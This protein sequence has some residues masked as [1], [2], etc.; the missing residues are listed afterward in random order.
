[1]ACPT[2]LWHYTFIDAEATSPRPATCES[3]LSL[4]TVRYRYP[5]PL[6]TSSSSCK[7]PP[8]ITC[9]QHQDVAGII[10]LERIVHISVSKC[11]LRQVPA[12]TNP[13]GTSY[14]DLRP[15]HLSTAELQHASSKSSTTSMYFKSYVI[16]PYHRPSSSLI[17][18]APMELPIHKPLPTYSL[19]YTTLWQ[20]VCPRNSCTHPTLRYRRT[21]Q[22]NLKNVPPISA[23][24]HTQTKTPLKVPSFR[25]CSD[26]SIGRI[27]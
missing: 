22:V 25:K 18:V 24:S 13:K 10:Y 21:N 9:R 11:H 12:A 15:L 14:L 7:L 17:M 23:L 16:V 1:M 3:Q 6:A 5:S 27:T 26:C 8:F 20:S 2:C 4:G 19:V